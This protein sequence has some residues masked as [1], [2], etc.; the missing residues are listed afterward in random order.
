MTQP[1]MAPAGQDQP[2]SEAGR[3]PRRG[4]GAALAPEIAG[5][6]GG[7]ADAQESSGA[8]P[9]TSHGSTDR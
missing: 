5:T 7:P 3:L 6:G 1:Q 9:A 8:A 4:E 2:R